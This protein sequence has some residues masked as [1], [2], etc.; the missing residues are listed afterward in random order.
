MLSLIRIAPYILLLLVLGYGGHWLIVNGL[1][2]TIA[3]QE[4]RILQLQ[5]N[6]ATLSVAASINEA[7]IRSLEEGLSRQK[8]MTTSLT[9]AN[10]VLQEE[11]DNYLGIFR[12]H[13]LTKLSLARPGLIES[14]I[15][16]GTKEVFTQLETD[17]S[18]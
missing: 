16:N 10:Q 15:N 6:N 5:E 12:R 1:E 8:E 11:K 2:G 4:N 7:T 17:T 14:R 18:Q 3:D 9:S 13:D